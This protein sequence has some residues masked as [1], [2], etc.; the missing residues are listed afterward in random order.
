[1]GTRTRF[2]I[3]PELLAWFSQG[4]L[5][6]S[7]LSHICDIRAILAKAQ[8]WEWWKCM[9]EMLLHVLSAANMLCDPLFE[10]RG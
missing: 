9:R 7:G 5:C 4:N 8:I 2:Q 1:M 6:V 10:T 3:C